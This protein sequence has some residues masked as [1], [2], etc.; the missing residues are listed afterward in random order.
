MRAK[1]RGHA[2]SVPPSLT[3][4]I[5]APDKVMGSK[6]DRRLGGKAGAL[7]SRARGGLNINKKV[8]ASRCV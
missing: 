8:P 5:Y 7:L 2:P 6:G 1:A 3:N 4:S